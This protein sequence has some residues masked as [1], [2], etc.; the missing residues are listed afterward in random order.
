[1]II[2]A[3]QCSR[4]VRFGARGAMAHDLGQEFSFASLMKPLPMSA[5]DTLAAV[6]SLVPPG[7]APPFLEQALLRDHQTQVDA[8]TIANVLWKLGHFLPS[9][10]RLHR[11]SS[12]RDPRLKELQSLAPDSNTVFIPATRRACPE[13]GETVGECF[14]RGRSKVANNLSSVVAAHRYKVFSFGSGVQYASF[15]EAECRPCRFRFLGG[16]QYRK[17]A[18]PAGQSNFGKCT[19][20][21]YTGALCD[22]VCFVMPKEKSWYAVDCQL[23]Q[24]LTDE[25]LHSGGTF[26][27]AV[28]VWSKQHPEE[29]QQDLILGRDLTQA[30]HTRQRLA[31]AWYTMNAL[32][33]AGPG[34]RNV[35]WSFTEDGL[36]TSLWEAVPLMRKEHLAK[37][38]AHAQHCPRCK[39]R[40]L[41]VVDGK[42]G[43]RRF[44]CAGLDGYEAVTGFDVQVH[45]GCLADAPAGQHFCKRCRPPRMRQSALIPQ[46]SVLGIV[47]DGVEPLGRSDVQYM[48]RCFDEDAPDEKFDVALPRAEVRADLLETFE[49]ACLRCRGDRGGRMARPGWVKGHKQLARWLKRSTTKGCSAPKATGRRQKGGKSQKGRGHA[50]GRIR[51]KPSVSRAV[52][53][54][55]AVA[56][57]AGPCGNTFKSHP[58]RALSG[59]RLAGVDRRATGRSLDVWGRQAKA[60]WQSEAEHR[61]CPHS[62]GFVRHFGGLGGIMPWGVH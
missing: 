8:R 40:L 58:P 5:F 61:R 53:S 3:A 39:E 44:V 49:K 38:A 30:R 6:L 10:L 27:S 12:M 7:L 23:L 41:I 35:R 9:V 21:K 32:R 46:E 60:C 56:E 62:G 55:S 36:E 22:E 51:K 13:C 14:P 24:F 43:A 33:L 28:L 29:R 16:W 20:M 4:W 2:G 42:R 57:G 11:P 54:S 50:K 1:M 31:D 45:T 26:A 34:A 15:Q 47:Q 48:V 52:P 19:D 17:N 37:V 25:F 18:G 59:H